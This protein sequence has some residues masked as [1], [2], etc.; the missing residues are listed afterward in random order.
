MDHY[1]ASRV[2]QTEQWVLETVNPNSVNALSNVDT[3]LNDLSV[4]MMSASKSGL[5]SSLT[6]YEELVKKQLSFN[7]E[8][9][10]EKDTTPNGNDEEGVF[11]KPLSEERQHGMRAVQSTLEKLDS[12]HGVLQRHASGVCAR[13][14]RRNRL[15]EKDHVRLYKEIKY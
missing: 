14:C 11:D 8:D 2:I 1:R 6:Q 12:K 5:Q 3:L 7:G 9:E 4:S 15:P 10:E 13:C